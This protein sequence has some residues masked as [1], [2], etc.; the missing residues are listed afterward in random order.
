MGGKGESGEEKEKVGGKG[1]SGRKRGKG[2]VAEIE[3]KNNPFC[4]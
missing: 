1:E 3:L 2:R 4:Q